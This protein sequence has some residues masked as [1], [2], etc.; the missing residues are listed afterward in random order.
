MRAVQQL[1]VGVVREEAEVEEVEAEDVV[2]PQ[3][4][5][6][7]EEDSMGMRLYSNPPLLVERR[8]VR[9]KHLRI[10]H[11]RQDKTRSTRPKDPRLM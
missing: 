5:G 11:R 7:R 2:D 8:V 10:E 1:E 9:V 4:L 3:R 6:L